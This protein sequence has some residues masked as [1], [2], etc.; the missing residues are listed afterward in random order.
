MNEFYTLILTN[1]EMDCFFFFAVVC[2]CVWVCYVHINVTRKQK[3][4][5]S[6]KNIAIA[7][8]INNLLLCISSFTTH[9]PTL[10][11]INAFLQWLATSTNRHL[12]KQCHT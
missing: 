4:D 2:H 8:M 3:W 10:T 5:C 7:T 11:L 12:K 1:R 6:R 9:N